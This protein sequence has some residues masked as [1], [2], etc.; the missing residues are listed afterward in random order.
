MQRC[1]TSGRDWEVDDDASAE[2]RK[3]VAAAAAQNKPRLT[4]DNALL[5]EPPSLVGYRHPDKKPQRNAADS[6]PSIWF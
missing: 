5:H 6:P 4:Q 1:V 2:L 3:T